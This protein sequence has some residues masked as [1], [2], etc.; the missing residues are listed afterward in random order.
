MNKKKSLAEIT[1]QKE[2][3]NLRTL[4]SQVVHEI[5]NPLSF[6]LNFS[7]LSKELLEDLRKKLTLK[8]EGSQKSDKLFKDIEENLDLIQ[9]HGNR[10][11]DIVSDVLMC[12]SQNNSEKKL[13]DINHLLK[14]NADYG[15][16]G[17]R[18]KKLKFE[19]DLEKKF[20]VLPLIKANE[21]DLS[22][23][24]LNIINNSCFALSEKKQPHR[25]K[26][27]ITTIN[28]RNFIEIKIWDNGLGIP[29]ELKETIFN[30][31]VSSKPSGVGFGLGL[32]ISHDIIVNRYCGKINVNTEPN[33]YTEFI[34]T[35]PKVE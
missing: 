14:K 17:F 16:E 4:I 13:V 23:V 1:F 24:F 18:I 6:V 11:N 28:R 27:I 32:F 30:P 3:F 29:L 35:L 26:I 9:K 19:V 34:I 33:Q 20:D 7:A 12:A 10:I 21:H 2:L 5:K 22:R 31:F 8:E 25:P 15:I